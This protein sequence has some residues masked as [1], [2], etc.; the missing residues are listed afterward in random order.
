[1]IA[2][3]TLALQ[4]AAASPSVLVVR[5]PAGEAL[6][7]IIRTGAGPALRPDLMAPAIDVTVLGIADGRYQ[8]AIAGTQLTLA[9][10]V[11]FVRSGAVIYPLATSPFV[12]D[13]KL[14]VPFQLIADVLPRAAVGFVYDAGRA[15][16][17]AG[18]AVATRPA[19][20][21]STSAPQVVARADGD[22]SGG[23]AS[24][25]A[26]P[27]GP[28]AGGRGPPSPATGRAARPPLHSHVVVVDAGHGGPDHGMSGPIGARLKVFEKD[29]TLAVAHEL[30]AQLTARGVGVVMTRMTDTL[31]GLYDRG[32]IANHQK[33]DL[34]ISIHVNAANPR[35]KNPQGAR[36]FETYFLS[37]ARTEDA[38][39]LEQMENDVVRFETAA[40]APRNDPL[41]LILND[42]AQNEHLRES[43]ALADT[44]QRALGEIH[45]GPSRGVKQAAFVVLVTAFMPAV[46]VEIGFGTNAAEASYLVDPRAQRR[47]AAAIADATVGYLQS[48]DRRVGGPSP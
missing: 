9:D 2:A 36:G 10:H 22:R 29:I 38:K 14:Y 48:Y 13:G 8:L 45:P 40:N 7:P 41:S 21:T 39:R 11:P 27:S 15:E 44:I 1:M 20:A 24:A 26:T 19:H 34:F 32:P 47:I 3:L 12:V 25:A 42:M 31:I 16:L 37:E 4:L 28:P 18:S 35:W 43:E 23:V 17:R 5:G 46:L 33:G 6:V 30:R